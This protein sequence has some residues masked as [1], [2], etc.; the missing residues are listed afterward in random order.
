MKSRLSQIRANYK[1]LTNLSGLYDKSVRI[2]DNLIT[3]IEQFS[4]NL[5]AFQSMLDTP[6]V[7]EIS[8][9]NQMKSEMDLVSEMKS[10]VKKHESSLN[11]IKARFDELRVS[12]ESVRNLSSTSMPPQ[13]E[14]EDLRKLDS[15]I[16]ELKERWEQVAGQYAS[17][18]AN[19]KKCLYMYHEQIKAAN[20]EKQG[21]KNVKETPEAAKIV[22]IHIL[23][24]SF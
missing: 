14:Y 9:I 13:H 1:E 12:I 24:L 18:R 7:L 8:N 21:L 10:L 17:R 3:Q 22:V 11:T 23:T 6:A 4:S 15:V 16:T 19:L 20:N 5:A 2:V